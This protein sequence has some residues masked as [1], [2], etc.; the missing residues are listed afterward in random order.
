MGVKVMDGH[1]RELCIG[2]NGI[3]ID[4]MLIELTDRAVVSVD[5]VRVGWHGT[6]AWYDVR[7]RNGHTLIE[8]CR[9]P[10]QAI[11]ILLDSHGIQGTVLTHFAGRDMVRMRIDIQRMAESAR[12]IQRLP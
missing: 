6:G 11:C 5:I 3:S 2:G 8:N 4:D 9:N 1:A 7:D 12:R 10:E